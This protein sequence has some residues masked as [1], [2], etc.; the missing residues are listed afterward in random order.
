MTGGN[1]GIRRA[2]ANGSD[3]GDGGDRQFGN[4]RYG[5]EGAV[6]D[7]A[8][9]MASVD[10]TDARNDVLGCFGRS[11]RCM[12]RFELVGVSRFDGRRGTASRRPTGAG[13]WFHRAITQKPPHLLIASQKRD[14][15]QANA[16]CP[17]ESFTCRRSDPTPPV[18]HPLGGPCADDSSRQR[19][20]SRPPIRRKAGARQRLGR[21]VV[22]ALDGPTAE[23]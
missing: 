8:G 5:H 4:V 20:P 9:A 13:G 21:P 3:P 11:D 18:R 6:A 10:Q 15:F 12:Q 19:R 1:T 23:C 14:R 2:I 17:W 7:M 16:R 22:S